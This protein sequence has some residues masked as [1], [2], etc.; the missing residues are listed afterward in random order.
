VAIGGARAAWVK[1]L[2]A[3]PEVGLRIRRGRFSG[4]AREPR[5]AAER[6]EARETYCGTVNP[7][8][9]AECMMHRAGRP[10]RAKIQELHG[11]WFSRGLPLVI[12]LR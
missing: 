8:D 1:N 4:V 5:D 7:F 6:Q 3:H 9:Y 2:E 11:R 12:E 10:S